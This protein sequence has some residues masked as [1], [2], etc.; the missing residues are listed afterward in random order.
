VQRL[1]DLCAS[2]IETRAQKPLVAD[3][4]LIAISSAWLAAATLVLALC[5][6]AARSDR[7]VERFGSA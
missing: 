7:A 3:M 2:L 5:G 1:L 4:L 6:T